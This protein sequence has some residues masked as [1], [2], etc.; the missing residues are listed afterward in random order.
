MKNLLHP[1]KKPTATLKNSTAK[2]GLKKQPA[3]NPMPGNSAYFDLSPGKNF[4]TNK[5][6]S[7]LPTAIKEDELQCHFL[8]YTSNKYIKQKK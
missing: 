8:L 6:K 1:L 5:C 3:K 7:L 4:F 2:T